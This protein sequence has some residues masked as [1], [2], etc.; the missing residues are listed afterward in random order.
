MPPSGTATG[1]VPDCP[2]ALRL[3]GLGYMRLQG[4]RDNV[5]GMQLY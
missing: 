2:V 3:P 5:I 1:T 4:A